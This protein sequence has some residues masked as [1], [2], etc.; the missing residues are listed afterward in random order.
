MANPDCN[1]VQC[2]RERDDEYLR[3]MMTATVTAFDYILAQRNELLVV[4]K[5]S[6]GLLDQVEMPD[7]WHDEW[8]KRAKAIIAQVEQQRVV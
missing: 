6:L 8:E 7:D 3:R 2:R 1:C 5:E 4:L